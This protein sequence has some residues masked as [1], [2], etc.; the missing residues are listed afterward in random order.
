MPRLIDADALMKY[1]LNQKSKTISCN[2]IARFPTVVGQCDDCKHAGYY[3][4]DCELIYCS[5][6]SCVMP[7]DG[8]CHRF[9]KRGD[10][11]DD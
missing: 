4:D 5:E 8:F 11:N 2:D 7:F 10:D 1:C 6:T 9:E 3:P